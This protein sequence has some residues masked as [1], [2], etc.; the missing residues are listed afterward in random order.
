M[1]MRMTTDDTMEAHFDLGLFDRPQNPLAVIH[2]PGLYQARVLR[3]VQLLSSNYWQHPE[4]HNRE[5]K[6]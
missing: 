2:H 6:P 3:H 1:V 5:V 4:R